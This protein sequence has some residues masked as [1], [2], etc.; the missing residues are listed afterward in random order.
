M[1]TKQDTVCYHSLNT[2]HHDS[3]ALLIALPSSPHLTFTT[4]LKG[5]FYYYHHVTDAEPEYQHD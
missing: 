2:M 4:A 5:R 3:R 1:M